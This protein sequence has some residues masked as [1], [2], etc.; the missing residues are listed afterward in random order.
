MQATFTFKR[1]RRHYYTSFLARYPEYLELRHAYQPLR[2][3][4]IDEK[5]A[6]F[7]D[8]ETI[9]AY[10]EGELPQNTRIIYEINDTEWIAWLQT[11]FWNVFRHS[12]NYTA[13][14]QELR[15]IG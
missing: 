6:F 14:L 5:H 13:R 15:K 4:I 1:G 7:R 3:F 11:V 10:R 12:V 8:E 9:H 2:G